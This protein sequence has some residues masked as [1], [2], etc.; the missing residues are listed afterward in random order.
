MKKEE[1]E[2]FNTKA[3]SSGRGLYILL[4]IILILIAIVVGIFLFR[5]KLPPQSTPAPTTGGRR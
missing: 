2:H 1:I 4:L 5:T 3:E